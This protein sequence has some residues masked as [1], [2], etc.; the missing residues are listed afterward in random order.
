MTSKIKQA[1]ATSI[2]W[3]GLIQLSSA[4]AANP[5]VNPCDA[6]FTS[7]PHW[8]RSHLGHAAGQAGNGLGGTGRTLE[9]GL[10]GTGLGKD[11]GLG[12]TGNQ[13]DPGL[14]GTGRMP[15]AADR[16]AS[17]E[18]SLISGVITGF[19]SVCVNGVEVHYDKSTPV[20]SNGVPSSVS[21]LKVGQWVAIRAIGKGREVSAQHI[22]VDH[23]IGGP[24]TRVAKGQVDVMGQRVVITHAVNRGMHLKAG[25][26]ITVSGVRKSNRELF[27]TR[28]DPMS[29]DD[30]CFVNGTL[31]G[32]GHV[33]GVPLRGLQVDPARFA[34]DVRVYGEWNGKSMDVSKVESLSSGSWIKPGEA[35]HIQTFS[36]PGATLNLAGVQMDIP[37]ELQTE[38]HKNAMW[39]I[40]GH[41]DNQGRGIPEAIEVFEAQRALHRGGTRRVVN[42]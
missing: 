22:A 26:H 32:K 36:K 12:G 33:E 42:P 7:N 9:P 20:L 28:I 17:A 30:P 6:G 15:I 10:G 13:M 3:L 2:L 21:A 37:S 4:W 29:A 14:G 34:S 5:A 40:R 16:E 8:L 27:A 35:F 24:V 11:N 23:V 18:F 31:N 41:V 39:V 1:L 38:T 25:D 19:A